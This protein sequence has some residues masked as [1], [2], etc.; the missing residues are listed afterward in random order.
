MRLP[1]ALAALPV[2]LAFAASA[3]AQEVDIKKAVDCQVLVTQFGDRV[4]PSKA[5]DDAKMEARDM[6]AAGNKACN[7]KNY[8]EGTTR[9]RE[10]LAKIEV[11]PIR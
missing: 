1:F 4:A 9:V 5:P 8:D 11:K 7:E 2:A 6:L 3:S 10:A